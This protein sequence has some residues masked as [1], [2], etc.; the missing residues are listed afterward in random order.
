[1]L[2]G[3]CPVIIPTLNR[4]EHLKRCIES[5]ERCEGAN[6]TELYIGLDYPPAEKY[7]E[8]WKKI[9]E[10]L[11]VKQDI[12]GFKSLHILRRNEN[13][14]A[15]KNI[16]ELKTFISGKFDRYIFSEDD[17]EFSPN[18]LV[19][20]NKG[21]TRFENNPNIYAICGYNYPVDMCGYENNYYFSQ[22]FSAWG[23][24]HWVKKDN[25]VNS[26]IKR[27]GYF[28]EFCRLQ[29]I[30]TFLKDGG[31]LLP[32]I[33]YI[34]SDYLGDVYI[35]TYIRSNNLFCV[36]PTVSTVRNWGHDGTGVNCDKIDLTK[37]YEDQNIQDIDSFVFDDNVSLSTP[38][39][40]R[41]TLIRFRSTKFRS[42]IKNLMMLLLYKVKNR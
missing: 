14:G 33:R 35:T 9:V 23:V 26:V 41:D 31:R 10:Y 28:K 13:F 27:D 24:G 17:N 25:I 6:N 15:V 7:E 19:Y 20:I 18:F 30:S 8:G 21:L 42:R 12:N 3:Y 37:C 16:E 2:N 38:L 22:E 1:M 34:N 36:F 40:V 11:E 4:Y 39:S 5:L 29:P 32:F